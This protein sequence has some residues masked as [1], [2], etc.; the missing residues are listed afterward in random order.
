MQSEYLVDK[1]YQYSVKEYKVWMGVIAYF[2]TLRTGMNKWFF[3]IWV[4]S[5]LLQ[6]IENK[7]G[8]VLF[9]TTYTI[10]KGRQQGAFSS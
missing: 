9:K 2:R 10:R 8:N 5:L 1:E 4:F 3:D 6:K 7:K